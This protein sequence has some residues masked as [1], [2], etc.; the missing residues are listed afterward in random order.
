MG[1]RPPRDGTPVDGVP[2]LRPPE[3]TPGHGENGDHQDSN[4]SP[5]V[6]HRNKPG[7][8]RQ[9]PGDH[10]AL[11]SGRSDNL[12]LIQMDQHFRSWGGEHEG[13]HGEHEEEDG[14]E[15]RK[16]HGWEHGEEHGEEHREEHGEHEEEHGA[17]SPVGSTPA[18]T[19]TVSSESWAGLLWRPVFERRQLVGGCGPGRRCGQLVRAS[20][21]RTP[22]PRP[23]R[24]RHPF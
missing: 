21:G 3:A 6:A 13:E 1:S 14:E 9:F 12:V 19:S 20:L 23:T 2:P 18:A 24:A 10:G 15:H 7:G 11:A 16:E 8:E 17:Q 22:H 5:R 4:E